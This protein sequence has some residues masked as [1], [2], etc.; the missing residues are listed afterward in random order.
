MESSLGPLEEL[1]AALDT[2]IEEDERFVFLLTTNDDELPLVVPLLE[3]MDEAS[4]PDV[5]FIDVAPVGDLVTYVNAVIEHVRAELAE[6]NQ[7]REQ[8]GREPLA[9]IPA[10]CQEEDVPALDRLRCLISHMTTWVTDADEQR[11]VVALL[12]SRILDR[13]AHSKIV[14]ALAPLAGRP[15]W[16]RVLRLIFRDDRRKPFVEEALRRLGATGIYLYT[17]RMTIRE[18]ADVAAVD[19]AN[20]NLSV[21]RRI[22][23]LMQCAIF[24][25][26]LGR[27]QAAIDK[28]KTLYQYYDEHGVTEMKATVLQGLGDIL[29]RIKRYP[30]ARDKYLQSL[31]LASDA[32]SLQLILHAVIPLGDIDMRL[33]SY[34]EAEQVYA[35]GVETADKLGN[36]YAKADLLEKCGLARK[37]LN[38]DRGATECFTAAANTAREFG[39]DARLATVLLRLR[40]ICQRCGYDDLRELYDAEL[41]NVCARLSGR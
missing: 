6:V 17:T 15:S 27:Y 26:A 32:K 38:N 18:L 3:Q 41:R 39:Y 22:N 21:P 10:E 36:A 37:A 23:A 1:Q 13:D 28:Y 25:T 7:A 9:A 16:S 11:M 8:E 12:P 35:L 20:K 2:F 24:D 34:D 19:V 31:D 30:A 40:K 29:G 33:G 5:Y 4:P 14:G